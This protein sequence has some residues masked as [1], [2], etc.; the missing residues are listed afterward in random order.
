MSAHLGGVPAD[1]LGVECQQAES[2]RQRREDAPRLQHAV[3][4]PQREGRTGVG[5]GGR[6]EDQSREAVGVVEGVQQ[7]DRAAHAVAEQEHGTPR[8]TGGDA[9]DEA[10]EVGRGVR[11]PVDERARS[12]R[13]AVAAMVDRPDREPARRELPR[14]PRVPPAVLG[15]PVGDDDVRT[16]RRGQVLPGLPGDAQSS[17]ARERAVR[18]L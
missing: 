11:E 3:G 1:V 8:V 2:R 4:E 18:V 17:L 16:R 15:G 14:E 9:V 6:A 5:R 7:R 10:V 13:A 12:L